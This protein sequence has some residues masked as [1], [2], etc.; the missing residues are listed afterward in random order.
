MLGEWLL[1]DES[2]YAC[3]QRLV[4]VVVAPAWSYRPHATGN[5]ALSAPILHIYVS[6]S[7]D[8]GGKPIA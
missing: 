8:T 7:G 5:K 4:D 2:R 3:K 1:V 6:F